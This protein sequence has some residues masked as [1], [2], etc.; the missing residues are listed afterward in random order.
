[1]LALSF[2]GFDHAPCAIAGLPAQI[3]PELA[4]V[5]RAG[6][7]KR[8]RQRRIAIVVLLEAARDP[9]FRSPR[10]AA[11]APEMMKLLNPLSRAARFAP[12][13]RSQPRA[14]VRR[15]VASPTP[16]D[17][18]DFTNGRGSDVDGPIRHAK[19]DRRTHTH[20]VPHTRA[21]PHRPDIHQP[22]LAA[23]LQ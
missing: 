5:A 22:P 10:R 18:R 13:G 11:E 16:L 14:D 4:A 21:V 2:S 6:D 3:A 17:I 20:E 8:R 15:G 7:R 19:P 1:M 23:A 12:F 9:A